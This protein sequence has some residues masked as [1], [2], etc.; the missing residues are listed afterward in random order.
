MMNNKATNKH[1]KGNIPFWQS[2]QTK[3]LFPFLLLIILTGGIVA[4][5]SYNFSSNATEKQ[6][7]ENIENQMDSLND[8]FELFFDNIHSTL[9]RVSSNDLLLDYEAGESDDLFQYFQETDDNSEMIMAIY[10]GFEKSGDM[11][12]SPSHDVDGFN[13][14]TAVWYEDAVASEGDIIWTEPYEDTG[15]G[16]TVVTVAK[17]YYND[18]NKLIGVTGADISV[19]TLLET[20]DKL[21]IGETGYAFLLDQSGTYLAHPDDNLVGESATDEPYFTDITNGNDQ[22]IIYDTS[23]D[24][25]R[26]VAYYTTPT[27]GWTLASAV[28]QSEFKKAAQAVILPISITVLIVL[29]IAVVISIIVTRR[30]TKPLTSVMKRMKLIASG[31]L[32]KKPF[33]PESNDEIAQLMFSTNDMTRSM[34]NLLSQIGAVVDTVNNNSNTLTRSVTEISYGTDQIASTMEG[35]ASGSET[36][37]NR[38]SE[39]SSSM[40]DLTSKI[41]V[42]NE[43]SEQITA[44]SHSVL[45]MTNK[46]NQLMSDSEQQ[47]K[48]VDFI[49]HDSVQKMQQ[50][51]K[52]SQE[53]SKLVSV[54]ED[55]ADQTNLLALNAAIEAARAGESGKGFAVVAD[56]VKI[57]AEQVSLSVSDITNIVNDIQDETHSVTESLQAGYTEVER[58][59]EQIQA[60]GEEFANI[61]TAVTNVAENVQQTSNSLNDIVKNSEQMNYFIQDIA[62]VTEEASAG[63]EETSAA[64]QQASSSME[65]VANSSDEL[66]EL[67]NELNN[68]LQQF[69]L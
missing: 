18:K 64:S 67:A 38:A 60:T 55:I 56:E 43:S 10:S 63:I 52:Q 15:T 49:V 48:K 27:T 3:I 57:L 51:D 24:Q 5:V 29:A 62:A 31:D 37:A 54:I 46:G 19:A 39:L 16:E 22:G 1:M 50:L 12:I 11:I 36:Q 7:T 9:N 25:E 40:I 69:K 13:P 34:H 21:E 2:I 6:M 14:R 28:Q 26:I 41:Q 44:S 65:E 30:I 32:T 20:I 33:E 66:A 45:D 42:T 53:I 61:K 58:G 17:S 8:T 47:M 23:E 4:L 35:L 59:T 68:M